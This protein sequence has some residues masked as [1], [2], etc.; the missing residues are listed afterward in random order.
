MTPPDAP[1]WASGGVMIISG[2][3]RCCVAGPPGPSAAP[4]TLQ[5]ADNLGWVADGAGSGAVPIAAMCPLHTGFTAVL[6]TQQSRLR[7][8]RAAR[9]LPASG[10]G[11]EDEK[12]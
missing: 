7:R 5:L 9:C 1:G 8:R 10:K 12:A 2:L 6:L 11:T 3:P 4:D